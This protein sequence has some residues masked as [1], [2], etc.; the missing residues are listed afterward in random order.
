MSDGRP[1]VNGGKILGVLPIGGEHGLV[2]K[3]RT[4]KI[5]G[6]H[7]W[8]LY[9]YFVVQPIRKISSRTCKR[10]LISYLNGSIF[11][12]ESWM[13]EARW[14]GWKATWDLHWTSLT[15]GL[16]KSLYS[17]RRLIPILRAFTPALPYAICRYILSSKHK[18][19]P[20]FGLAS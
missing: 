20:L 19:I 3:Y 15:R 4:L 12:S 11:S 9:H 18:K 8:H 13:S 2:G 14:Y 1:S 6:F 17:N 10:L 7:E 5:K 16:D